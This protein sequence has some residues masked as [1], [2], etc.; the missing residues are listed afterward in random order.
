MALSWLSLLVA[1][2]VGIVAGTLIGCIGVGGVVLVPLLLLRPDIKVH[3]AVVACMAAYMPAGLGGALAYVRKGAVPWRSTILMCLPSILSA[4]LGSW[5]LVQ[6]SGHLVKVI[7]YSVM[8]ATSCLSALRSI[9]AAWNE[10]ISAKYSPE[11]RS[12][13]DFMES[14][15]REDGEGCTS[16]DRNN[17]DVGESGELL[18]EGSCDPDPSSPVRR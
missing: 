16:S 9:H 11:D 6:M 13:R 5:T 17:E 8:L 1:G 14:E 18:T 12:C 7:L 4:L 10:R 2:L 15:D 3:I